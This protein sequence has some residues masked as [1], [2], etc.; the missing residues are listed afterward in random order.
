MC[1]LLLKMEVTLESCSMRCMLHDWLRAIKHRSGLQ[2]VSNLKL[3]LQIQNACI[4]QHTFNYSFVYVVSFVRS[5]LRLFSIFPRFWFDKH[6]FSQC[7]HPITF[8][9]C[10]IQ[11]YIEIH[12]ITFCIKRALEH[13]TIQTHTHNNTHMY[14][15]EHSLNNFRHTVKL[16]KTQYILRKMASSL[17]LTKY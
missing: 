5:V 3:E 2:F 7:K 12:P 4:V 15:S 16:C 6:D 13:L 1:E 17:L 10:N 9:P 14:S 8:I 11:F